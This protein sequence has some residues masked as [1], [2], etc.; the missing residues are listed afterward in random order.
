MELRAGLFLII[1]ERILGVLSVDP[2]ST[3]ISSSAT[4][5]RLFMHDSMRDSSFFTIIHIESFGAMF[6]SPITRFKEDAF[7]KLVKEGYILKQVFEN[8]GRI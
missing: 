1:E 4:S 3:T 6:D 2:V 8:K 7:L 5:L